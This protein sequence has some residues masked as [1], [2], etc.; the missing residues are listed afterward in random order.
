[1]RLERHRAP[2]KDID[3]LILSNDGT[4]DEVDSFYCPQILILKKIIADSTW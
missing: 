1:M 4:I 2:A 3:Q